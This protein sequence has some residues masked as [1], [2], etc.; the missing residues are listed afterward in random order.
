[1]R[2][3]TS[4]DPR[5]REH[6][7]E[8]QLHLE[9]F[10]Q[11]KGHKGHKT[12]NTVRSLKLLDESTTAPLF[13]DCTP[14]SLQCIS[15]GQVSQIDLSG[16]PIDKDAAEKLAAALGGREETVAAAM[17]KKII[18]D[19][20]SLNDESAEAIAAGLKHHHNT[21]TLKLGGNPDLT[22][23]GVTALLY[24]CHAIQVFSVRWSKQI[25]D[26]SLIYACN[27]CPEL[28][29]LDLRE[30]AVTNDGVSYI[31]Q[32]LNKLDF[33]FLDEDLELDE[34]TVLELI[35]YG[36]RLNSDVIGSLMIR[37]CHTYG[38]H[39]VKD[40]AK[41]AKHLHNNEEAERAAQINLKNK[42][43]LGVVENKSISAEIE[44]R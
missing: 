27:N 13:I 8:I 28:E 25:G 29:E 15:M 39:N 3:V 19:G 2:F 10:L 43:D 42:K 17:V 22:D 21:H 34:D 16:V 7:C 37:L 35:E 31:P 24:E 11:H 4:T 20:C 38:P 26:T 1:M 6:I 44:N 40:Y 30:T 9:G 14:Q 41:H 33:L 36:A 32:H 18:L 23:D 12:Y 5:I